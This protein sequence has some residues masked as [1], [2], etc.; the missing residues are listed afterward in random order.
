MYVA[1]TDSWYP[2]RIVL[3]VA[4]SFILSS[5]ALA[6]LHSPHWLILTALVG[7]N[8]VIFAAT[9]FCIMANILYRRGAKPRL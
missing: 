4:G 2:E 7:T 6:C 9:G 8:L 3:L 1:K 5:A